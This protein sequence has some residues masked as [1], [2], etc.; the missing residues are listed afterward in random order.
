MNRIVTLFRPDFHLPLKEFWNQK[1]TSNW[2]RRETIVQEFYS[3]WNTSLSSSLFFSL[4]SH[5]HIR[6]AID[7][8]W[9]EE[10][11]RNSAQRRNHPFRWLKRRGIKFTWTVNFRPIWSCVS[12]I[13]DHLNDS[14]GSW[15][16]FIYHLLVF[17]SELSFIPNVLI[18]F[19][20][21]LST[22]INVDRRLWKLSRS[23][24]N[25]SISRHYHHYSHQFD[26]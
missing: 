11:K 26:K 9:E 21:F 2:G 17:R 12:F 7:W 6:S 4:S 10:L 3:N 18:F 8:E 22:T 23:L 19:S 16:T 13:L 20:L 25:L 5:A 14:F 1:G 24:W 15:V